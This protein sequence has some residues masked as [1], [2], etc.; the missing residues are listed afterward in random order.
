MGHTL[1]AYAPLTTSLSFFRGINHHHM[2]VQNSAEENLLKP[3]SRGEAGKAT[4][5]GGM[6]TLCDR[7]K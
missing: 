2:L 1:S 7:G 3:V 4:Y 6:R 5:V